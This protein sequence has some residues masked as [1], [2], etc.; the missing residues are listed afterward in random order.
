MLPLGAQA[1][2]ETRAEKHAAARVRVAHRK[3]RV[4]ALEAKLAEARSEFARQ[5]TAFV[6]LCA[7]PQVGLR[8]FWGSILLVLAPSPSLEFPKELGHSFRDLDSRR[9]AAFADARSEYLQERYGKQMLKDLAREAD[10]HF[11]QVSL[12]SFFKK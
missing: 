7:R 10:D 9:D 12:A 1:E 2:L 5:R 8:S 4:A 3:E 11:K 6:A